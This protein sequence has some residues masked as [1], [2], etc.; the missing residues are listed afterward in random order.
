MTVSPMF[1]VVGSTESV[2][3]LGDCTRYWFLLQT[4]TGQM[5]RRILHR[6]SLPGLI[7]YPFLPLSASLSSFFVEF[8]RLDIASTL[9]KIYYLDENLLRNGI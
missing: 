2:D 9:A 1:Q 7:V 5:L 6:F 4:N 3:S 8:G